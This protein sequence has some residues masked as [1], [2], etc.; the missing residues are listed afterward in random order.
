MRS[1]KQRPGQHPVAGVLD[2]PST[3]FGDFRIHE[4]AQMV[5]KL[6]VRPL[7]VHASQSAI[8]SDI[9]RQDGCEPS[10]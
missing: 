10:L 6:C 8:T 1:L 9:G 3:V 2:N 5:L 4:Q 7:F